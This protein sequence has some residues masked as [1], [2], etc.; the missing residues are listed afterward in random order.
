MAS[1]FGYHGEGG[2]SNRVQRAGSG[3]QRVHDHRDRA[4]PSSSHRA[5]HSPGAPRC[6]GSALVH[7]HHSV[8]SHRHVPRKLFHGNMIV[9]FCFRFTYLLLW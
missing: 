7:V 1:G 6:G 9:S 5:E 4:Q 2:V 8:P 3:L